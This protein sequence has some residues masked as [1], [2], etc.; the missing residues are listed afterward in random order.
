[1]AVV[2]VLVIVATVSVMALT[3][4]W[5]DNAIKDTGF[6]DTDMYD[7]MPPPRGLGADAPAVPGPADLPAGLTG[8]A[9]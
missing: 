6:T 3:V 7:D 1:V 4:L 8:G 2:G 5:W 9:A